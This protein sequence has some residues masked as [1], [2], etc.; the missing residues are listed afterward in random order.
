VCLLVCG[1]LLILLSEFNNFDKKLTGKL[2]TQK[3]GSVNLFDESISCPAKG[4]TPGFEASAKCDAAANL[5]A[6]VPLGLV[7]TGTIVPPSID[8]FG[9]FVGKFSPQHTS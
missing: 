3:S 4:S 8:T 6:T 7:A 5:D 2:K 9:V 1:P